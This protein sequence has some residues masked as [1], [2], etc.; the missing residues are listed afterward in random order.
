MYLLKLVLSILVL[1]HC[2]SVEI[3]IQEHEARKLLGEAPEVAAAIPE[4]VAVQGGSGTKKKKKRK[5]AT[6]V[7]PVPVGASAMFD[8]AVDSTVSNHIPLDNAMADELVQTKQRLEK[9]Q[10]KWKE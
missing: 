10:R 1:Y 9:L 4:A 6:P 3:E 7:V 5:L 2:L 8:F